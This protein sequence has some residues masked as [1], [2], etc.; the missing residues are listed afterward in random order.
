M[1]NNNLKFILDEFDDSVLVEVQKFE[2]NSL[3][4]TYKRMDY[5]QFLNYVNKISEKE[6]ER[7]EAIKKFKEEEMKR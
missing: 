3:I 1:G 7:L 5:F 6:E 2:S 4:K